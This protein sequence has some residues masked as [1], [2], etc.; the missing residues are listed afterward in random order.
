MHEPLAAS[1]VPRRVALLV[2]G[3]EGGGVATYVLELLARVDR[4]RFDVRLVSCG[5]GPFIDR[6]RA[7]GLAYELLGANWPPPLREN[8]AGGGMRR[9]WWSYPK[10]GVW[11]LRCAVRLARYLRRERIELVHTHYYHFHIV[12][13]L[14]RVAAPFR[15]VWHWHGMEVQRLVLAPA[16]LWRALTHRFVWI[17]AISR[18][19]QQSIRPLAGERSTVVYN[20]ISIGLPADRRAELRELL[21]VPPQS[22]IVG[23][24]GSLNPIKG[25][26]DFL[27]A[28]A[29][30]CARRPGVHFAFIGG[31]NAPTMQPYLQLL[32]EQ[33]RRLGLEQRVHFVGY[34]ADAVTLMSGFDVSVVCTLPPGEGF[35]LVII[36]AMAQR[37]PVVSTNTGAAGELITDGVDGLLVPPR[38]P[39]A[40]AAA[41][42]RLLDDE[43]LRERIAAAGR[44]TCEE[45]FDIR[46]TVR[47]VEATYLRALAMGCE[48]R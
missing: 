24:V 44:R 33:R 28:A 21:G 46:R 45:R 35:G 11:T 3:R 17:I 14:A 26:R 30:V 8:V 41:I 22:R 27:D 25:H 40:M 12:A 36:E 38:D 7:A 18:A 4:R 37:V 20:G 9:L 10:V 48:A 6:V 15:C 31:H 19:T 32:L 1:R 47:E 29:R 34:R 2:G 16:A 13:G 42:E 5:D 43:G 23:L 39:A